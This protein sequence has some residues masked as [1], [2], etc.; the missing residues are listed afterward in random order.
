MMML[1]PIVVGMAISVFPIREEN[2]RGFGKLCRNMATALCIIIIFKTG[3]LVTGTLPMVTGLAAEVMTGALLACYFISEYICGMKGSLKIWIGLSLIPVI[4]MTRTGIVATAITFPLTL[5]P[6]KLVKRIA[7]FFILGV[8]ALGLFHTD[9]V[10][11]KMFYTG[12]GD[13]EDIRYEN[14]DLR[15]AGRTAMWKLMEEEVKTSPWWGHG[16]NATEG[17]LQFYTGFSTHPHNDWLRLRF[18]YGYVGTFIFA[19]CLLAQM[20]H[21]WK[22][23]TGMKGRKRILFYAGASAFAP[24]AVF[25]VTDNI[26]LYC[27]FFG[28]LQFT[29]LGI[30]YAAL[31]TAQTDAARNKELVVN[32]NIK[33]SH[34]CLQNG[35]IR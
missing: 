30:A 21:A 5:A 15:T 10:Q 26:I 4:A 25:M 6:L 27:A 16:A 23:A 28:N 7:I 12:Q 29:L 3:I 13:I 18:D 19:A 32:N 8:L 24:F 9:R 1:C 2:L 17:F 31:K 35:P 20:I 33:P 14:P 22:R 11:Q 34:F